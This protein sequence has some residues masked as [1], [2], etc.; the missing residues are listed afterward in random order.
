M[1]GGD[2][3]WWQWAE[4]DES[5]VSDEEEAKWR[6]EQMRRR[7]AR[8]PGKGSVTSPIEGSNTLLDEGRR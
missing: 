7:T 4:L 5:S 3:E 2:E 8:R 6:Q 1:P